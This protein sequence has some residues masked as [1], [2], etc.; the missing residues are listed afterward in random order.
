MGVCSV[1]NCG[2][3]NSVPNKRQLSYYSF[4]KNWQIK[5]EWLEFC[6]FPKND[7]THYRKT[8]CSAHFDESAIERDLRAELLGEKKRRK[9]KPDGNVN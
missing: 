7:T 8:V 4:P 6:G 9:L 1:P 5:Y 2:N 3:S